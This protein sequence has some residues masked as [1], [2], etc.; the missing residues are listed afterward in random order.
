[1]DAGRWCCALP[2]AL[3]SLLPPTPSVPDPPWSASPLAKQDHLHVNNK[4][5]TL[6]CPTLQKLKITPASASVPSF[7][8]RRAVSPSTQTCCTHAQQRNTLQRLVIGFATHGGLS[9]SSAAKE[10]ATGLARLPAPWLSGQ[11]RPSPAQ[12]AQQPSSRGAK[13]PNTAAAAATRA[14]ARL[15]PA[16]GL[17][18]SDRPEA[19]VAHQQQFWRG[20]GSAAAAAAGEGQFACG[21]AASCCSQGPPELTLAARRACTQVT[22]PTSQALL[23]VQAF[24]GTCSDE[25]LR[26]MRILSHLCA[27]TY[28]MGQLTVRQEATSVRISKWHAGCCFWRSSCLCLLHG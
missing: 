23:D 4:Q 2:R 15:E 22:Q 5:P 27:Q 14:G 25:E 21:P 20:A 7:S 1:M 18:P 28:Y 19:A 6:L 9:P 16:V 11:E 26:H 24:L 12:D 10:Q 8:T 13:D 3:P 17:G